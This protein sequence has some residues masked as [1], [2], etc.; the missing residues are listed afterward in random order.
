MENVLK[1]KFQ[2]ETGNSK[3]FQDTFFN[4]LCGDFNRS[5][6]IPYEDAI[7]NPIPARA[8]AVSIVEGITLEEEVEFGANTEL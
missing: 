6:I 8:M 1:E 5:E 7:H 2:A 3:G 4:K